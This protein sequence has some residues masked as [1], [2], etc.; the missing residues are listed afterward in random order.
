VGI[1]PADNGNGIIV[2]VQELL[3]SNRYATLGTGVL[4]FQAGRK[5][6]FLERDLEDVSTVPDGVAFDISAWGV[7][8][9]RLLDIGLRPA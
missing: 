6:D 7:V 1:K 5:V 8:A 4:T 2:Y 3:G 9:V